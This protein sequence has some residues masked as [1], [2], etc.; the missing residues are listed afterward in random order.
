[1]SSSNDCKRSNEH[2]VN[3]ADFM[4]HQPK[5]AVFTL[6]QTEKIVQIAATLDSAIQ[7]VD[8]SIELKKLDKEIDGLLA[9]SKEAS[10]DLCSLERKVE[11][12]EATCDKL[13]H[14]IVAQK[15]ELNEVESALEANKRADEARYNLVKADICSLDKVD[16]AISGELNQLERV[17]KTLASKEMKDSRVDSIITSLLSFASK[18]DIVRLEAEIK[19]LEGEARF[20][21]ILRR[22]ALLEARKIED[23]RVDSLMTELVKQQAINAKQQK[24]IESLIEK[25][26]HQ[27]EAIRSLDAK[28]N[29]NSL[30]L[31]SKIDKLERE[32][33]SDRKVDANQTAMIATLQGQISRMQAEIDK[34]EKVLLVK[35]C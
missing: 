2:H 4:P 26:Q 20:V 22:L 30:A 27:D 23:N 19:K 28:I 18:G 1:M 32:D 3:V 12:V 35:P 6:S 9:F 10:K 34:L 31:D 17:V 24:M 33:F 21:E 13:A 7:T 16:K 14:S 29:R 15:K 25:N 5:D 8:H 11:C